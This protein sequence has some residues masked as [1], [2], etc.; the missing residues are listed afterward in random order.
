M[1][2][3]F[4]TAGTDADATEGA[5]KM[6]KRNIYGYILVTVLSALGVMLQAICFQSTD[7]R[8][9][10]NSPGGAYGTAGPVPVGTPPA[11]RPA[12]GYVS[13]TVFFKNFKSDIFLECKNFEIEARRVGGAQELLSKVTAYGD[14]STKA[15]RYSIGSTPAATAFQLIVLKPIAMVGRCT[16]EAFTADGTLPIT[17]KSQQKLF[18]NITVR[19]LSCTVLK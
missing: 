1:I 6:N 5:H 13:G 7:A 14:L 16:Q 8:A 11:P 19:N 9:I 10:S 12:V 4:V 2:D 17:L 15:C 3:L 18:R